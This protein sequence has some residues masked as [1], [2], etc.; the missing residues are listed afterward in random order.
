MAR[1]PESLERTSVEVLDVQH[2]QLLEL[3]PSLLMKADR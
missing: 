1:L 3:P 2:N